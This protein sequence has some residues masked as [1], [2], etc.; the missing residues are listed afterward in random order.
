MHTLSHRHTQTHTYSF[1][2]QTMCRHPPRSNQPLRRDPERFGHTLLLATLH[3]P[4][5]LLS[6]AAWLAVLFSFFFYLRVRW[7]DTHTHTGS[8][9]YRF[10]AV[11]RG[12]AVYLSFLPP[13]WVKS[14]AFSLSLIWLKRNCRAFEMGRK[15]DQRL[16]PTVLQ[17]L[18]RAGSCVSPRRGWPDGGGTALVPV[19]TS[20]PS[21]LAVRHLVTDI[22]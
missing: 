20:A 10:G 18:R 9:V 6:R 4:S 15:E 14:L 19:Q 2:C 12:C 5:S 21:P 11:T 1:T 16:P 22:F 7:E 17:H 13:L 3:T 8:C